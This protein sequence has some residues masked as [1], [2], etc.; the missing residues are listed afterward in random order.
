[1]IPT[2][3]LG[4]G[5]AVRLFGTVA[6]HIGASRLIYGLASYMFLAGLLQRD[7]RAVA[8]PLLVYFVYGTLV[9]GV[10]AIQPELSWET[11]LAAALISL[12]SAV[13]GPRPIAIFADAAS[14]LLRTHKGVRGDQ[15]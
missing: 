15:P 7:R 11:H 5:I 9:W 6:D 3:Y 13:G 1:V 14:S 2:V 8:A 10:L 12:G 4:S